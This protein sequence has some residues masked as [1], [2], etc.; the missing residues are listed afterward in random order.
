MENDK[1]QTTPITPPVKNDAGR[2]EYRCPHCQKFLFKGNVKRL[3]MV[4]HHCQK[5][6][7][8]DASELFGP[9]ESEE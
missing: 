1:K 5:M 3:K 4:C 2:K 6:I 7:D 8:A 9:V